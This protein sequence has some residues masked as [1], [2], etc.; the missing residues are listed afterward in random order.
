MCVIFFAHRVH[1]VHPLILIANRDEFYDRPTAA[2]SRWEDRPE[3]F[4]G[5]DL[6]HGGT[7][8]GITDSGRFAA[9]TNYRQPSAPGGKRSRGALVSGFLGSSRS[10]A[11]FLDK[12][13]ECSEYFSGFNL[14][15]GDRDTVAYFSNR[16]GVVRTLEPGIYGLS[17]HLLDT[18]WPKV[19]GGKERFAA[20]ITPANINP[21]NLF[22]I[23]G[24]KS[25]APDDELPDTGVGYEREKLLS[26]IFIETPVYGTRSSSIVLADNDFGLSLEERTFV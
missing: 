23:L 19:R 8:L 24:D 16:E 26:A 6:V 3:I 21:D 10:P 18:P 20:A 11:D 12:I 15:A 22:E 17:N 25:L 7:W 2:A 1:P 4:A 9:V 5:R 13:R 14:I